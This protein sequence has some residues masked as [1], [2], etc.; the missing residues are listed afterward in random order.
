MAA[1]HWMADKNGDRA[2]V[3]GACAGWAG[4]RALPSGRPVKRNT[5]PSQ[6]A[7]HAARGKSSGEPCKSSRKIAITSR[8]AAI[9]G[10]RNREKEF[11][12]GLRLLAVHKGLLEADVVK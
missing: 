11:P 8:W 3:Y 10:W 12:R 1:M 9:C 5:V 6:R 4:T 2:R 7:S